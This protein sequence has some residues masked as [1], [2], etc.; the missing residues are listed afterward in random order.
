MCGCRCSWACG[1]PNLKNLANTRA[2]FN[3]DCK[4]PSNGRLGESE[5]KGFGVSL[6]QVYP[7]PLP[8][9]LSNLADATSLV[10]KTE[11]EQP[12]RGTGVRIRKNVC[13]SP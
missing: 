7:W 4:S 2:K 11:T 6:S 8:L 1:L 3:Q 9:L 5:S 10:S 12:L 13:K